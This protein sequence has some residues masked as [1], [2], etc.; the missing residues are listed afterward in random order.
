MLSPI[1]VARIFDWGAPNHKKIFIVRIRT[2]DWGKGRNVVGEFNFG[3]GGQPT[4]YIIKDLNKKKCS[5]LEGPIFSRKLGADQKIKRS[6]RDEIIIAGIAIG[7]GAR[8]ASPLAAPMLSPVSCFRNN[9][10]CH[11]EE[12]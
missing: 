3:L 1:G 5:R 11:N 7:R 4:T 9:S 6:S 12:N 2:F 10:Y 8:A